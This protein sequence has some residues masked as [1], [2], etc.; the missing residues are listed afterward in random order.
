MREGCD[1][2]EGRQGVR[3]EQRGRRVQQRVALHVL[4]VNNKLLLKSKMK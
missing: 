4:Q 3:G 1:G 2:A